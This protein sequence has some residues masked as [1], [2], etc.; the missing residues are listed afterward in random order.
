VI[1][2]NSLIVGHSSMLSDALGRG[3]LGW[4]LRV[5]VWVVDSHF[6][7]IPQTHSLTLSVY[8]NSKIR[9]YYD[10][11]CRSEMVVQGSNNPG[12]ISSSRA[13]VR[14]GIKP[15]T[16]SLDKLELFSSCKKIVLKNNPPLKT[17]VTFLFASFFLSLTHKRR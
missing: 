8:T 1:V 3:E 14:I 12:A 7:S 11:I 17:D 9:T 5:W 16:P 2:L 10:Q 15:M 13:P 4:W 6:H